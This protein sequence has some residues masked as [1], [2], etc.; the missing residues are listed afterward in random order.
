MLDDYNTEVLKQPELGPRSS[1]LRVRKLFSMKIDGTRLHGVYHH[2]L[3]PDH[4]TFLW[5]LNSLSCWQTEC[6]VTNSLCGTLLSLKPGGWGE[7]GITVVDM[8]ARLFAT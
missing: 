8:K 4:S 6:Q 2:M 1:S 5:A 3:Q 7:K